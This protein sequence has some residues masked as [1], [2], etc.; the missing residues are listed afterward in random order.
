MTSWDELVS[1]GLARRRVELAPFTTYK[2][3]GPADLFVEADTPESLEAVGEAWRRHPLPV[4]VLGR[5]SN[6]LIADDGFRG[7][8]VRL[9]SGFDHATIDAEG[10]VTAG[11]AGS[12]PRL[13]RAVAAA[14]WGGLEWGVGIPGS[15][16]G[17][18][19]QNAG[20]FGGEVVDRLVEAEVV[21][22][23]DGRRNWRSATSLDLSYRHSNLLPTEVVVTARFHTRPTDPAAA[24]EEMRRVTAWR[25]QTQPGGTLNAGSVF[26]N[27]PGE[28]AAGAIIDRLGLKGFQVGTVRVSPRHANFIEASREA[29]AADV[30]RL[31]A[32]VAARVL[33]ATGITLEPE[34]QFV[35]FEEG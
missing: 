27:P 15:V 32:E 20:C 13:A 12:L 4:L 17:A 11:A 14:G 33:A 5:G 25:R 16:G 19:R 31:V 3:G 29:V 7:V 9:G 24:A 26:K 10:M 1:E 6:L 30:R 2:L 8:V 22:L 23:A 28:E 18:V 21:S 34:I 35:G